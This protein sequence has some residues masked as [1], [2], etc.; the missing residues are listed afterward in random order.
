MDIKVRAK[1]VKSS[2]PKIER[3]ARLV[4]GKNLEESF[5]M[6]GFVKIGPAEFISKLL[7]SAIG[8]A[9]Q[10]NLKPGNLYIKEIYSNQGPTLKRFRAGSKGN[11]KPRRHKMSHITIIVGERGEVN[12][13]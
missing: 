12:G 5:N 13:S 3:V 2:S 4:R 7:N 9:K 6:I 11:A 8:R 10:I 1:Y